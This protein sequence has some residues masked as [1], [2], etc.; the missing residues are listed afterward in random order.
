VVQI[1]K[2][3]SL[4]AVGGYT[5]VSWGDDLPSRD[6]CTGSTVGAYLLR[7]NEDTDTWEQVISKSAN[8]DLIDDDV[9]SNIVGPPRQPA[10]KVARAASALTGA[11]IPVPKDPSLFPPVTT[12]P[13]CKPPVVYFFGSEM[14]P[15]YDYKIVASA[16][17]PGA[18]L[19]KVS[20]TSVAGTCGHEAG[21]LCCTSGEPCMGGNICN[22]STKRCEQ[23]GMDEQA[24]CTSSL[25]WI[26]FD[27]Y[28]S[29]CGADNI[30][31]HRVCGEPGQQCCDGWC[32]GTSCEADGK[33]KV[34]CGDLNQSCCPST[35]GTRP[36]I[37][38]TTCQ[39]GTCR[40]PCGGK[41][42]T[43]CAGGGCNNSGT[44]CLGGTCQT[45]GGE[46]QACCGGKFPCN[47]P[48]VCQTGMCTARPVVNP[49]AC[50]TSVQV[51]LTTCY[52]AD[53]TESN[54]LGNGQRTYTGC[55]ADANSAQVNALLS[56]GIDGICTSS[57]RKA[58]CCQFSTESFNSC[59]CQ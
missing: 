3:S 12:L 13:Q 32:N 8:G 57:T 47:A 38:G 23:C 43:C 29:T 14:P 27:P 31:H 59:L 51:T 2:Y 56:A 1:N 9:P 19:R 25:A 39:V 54:I 20:F 7:H 42:Q 48:M 58:G 44:T 37:Q 41:G 30:C 22:A 35:P 53:L 33:C 26:C 45:C 18:V 28:Y 4:Y 46:N 55:G 34:P 15:Q 21:A 24:C 36:C 10:Q 16:R 6:D 50:T 17:L 52:N 40:L 49:P 11:L 5:E